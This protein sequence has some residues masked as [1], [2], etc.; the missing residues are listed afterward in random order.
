MAILAYMLVGLVGIWSRGKGGLRLPRTPNTLGSVWGYLCGSRL[1]HDFAE[2]ACV[3]T[4]ERDRAVK[5]MGRN[6]GLQRDRGTD[7]AMRWSV[8]YADGGRMGP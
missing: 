4:R 8:D 7:G 2:F 1:V 3:E 5:G 6:Y